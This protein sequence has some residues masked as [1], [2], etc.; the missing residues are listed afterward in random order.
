[1]NTDNAIPPLVLVCVSL[2]VAAAFSGMIG[3]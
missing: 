1:M 2:I 3:Y